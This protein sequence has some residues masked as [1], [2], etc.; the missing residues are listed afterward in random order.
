M[1]HRRG[2]FQ[3]K[4]ETVH[5]TYGSFGGNAFAA[6]VFGLNVLSAQHLPETILR[7]RGEWL[8]YIDGVQAPSTSFAV[9]VG[10]ILVPEG[11]G[12]TVLWSP[13]TD[14]DA[15]WIWWDTTVLAYE[16]YVVDVIDNPGA[17]FVRRVIDNKAMRKSRN[18]EMQFVM[19]NATIG[20]AGSANV[21]GA[22]RFLAGS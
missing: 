14:G 8:A 13:I 18:M 16:E 9:S 10:L 11:T 7:I 15:P 6:G 2:G 1:A 22:A 17:S 3:K 21:Q 19:E 20:N 5:W 12:S 4:I